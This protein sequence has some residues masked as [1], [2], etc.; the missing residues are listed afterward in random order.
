MLGPRGGGLFPLLSG[1]L[2]GCLDLMEKPYDWLIDGLGYTLLLFIMYYD[3]L[4]TLYIL[5]FNL[6]SR[7]TFEAYFFMVMYLSIPSSL[8]RKPMLSVW[9][10]SFAA[11]LSLCGLPC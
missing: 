9:I 11:E 10:S 2:L 3:G 4:D 5:E 1:K 8:L 6:V 7:L